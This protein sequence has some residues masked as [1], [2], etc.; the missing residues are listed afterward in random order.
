MTYLLLLDCLLSTTHG[1]SLRFF[2]IPIFMV[3][4]LSWM[5]I[6]LKSLFQ[7]QTLYPLEQNNKIRMLNVQLTKVKIKI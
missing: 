2:W 1:G 7:L 5:G 3:F 6:E 4:G